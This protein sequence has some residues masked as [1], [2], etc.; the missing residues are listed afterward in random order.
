[1]REISGIR[2]PTRSVSRSDGRSS[3]VGAKRARQRF[4]GVALRLEE[5]DRVTKILHLL[6]PFKIYTH[7]IRWPSQ[8]SGIFVRTLTCPPKTLP[9][10]TEKLRKTDE[11]KGALR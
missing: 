11:G 5:R 8:E 7:S 10:I 9:F 4:A 6:L 1:M 3:W 2:Q